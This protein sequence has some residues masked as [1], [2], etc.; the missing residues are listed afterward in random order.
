MESSSKEEGIERENAGL[1]GSTQLG[2]E[3]EQAY[4]SH[5]HVILFPGESIHTDVSSGWPPGRGESELT[6]P[7]RLVLYSI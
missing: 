6:K 4:L 3:Y 7:V 2:K 5:V 1:L